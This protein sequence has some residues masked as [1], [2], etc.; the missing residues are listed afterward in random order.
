MSDADATLDANATV[1]AVPVSAKREVC[2]EFDTKATDAGLAIPYLVSINGKIQSKLGKLDGTR[3]IKRMVDIGSKVALYLNS[4]VHPD[5][6]STPVYAVEVGNNNVL[7]KI[8]EKTGHH[9]DLRPVIGQPLTS[10]SQGWDCYQAPLT[11]N[12]WMAISHRYSENEAQKCLAA[13]TP[14][15]VRQAISN[16]YRG[17]RSARLEIAFPDAHKLNIAFEEGGNAQDNIAGISTTTD[18]LTRTHPIAFESLLTEAYKLGITDMLVTSCWRPCYGSIAHRAGLGLDVCYI[19]TPTEKVKINRIGLLLKGHSSNPYVSDKEKTLR[20]EW[21]ELKARATREKDVK[22]IDAAEEKRSERVSEMKK[23]EPKIMRDLR[24]GLASH[25]AVSQ[26][27]DPWY[28]NFNT[29]GTGE[30]NINEQTSKVE[31]G[32]AHHLHI[33]IREHGII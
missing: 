6:R 10:G 16:I 18:V 22:A 24:A 7:I 17:L 12:I 1:K 8:T 3:K 2:Y 25:R 15:E 20:A 13:D 33:T 11:G 19:A 28:M 23:S 4:D 21:Q 9:A 30:A 14:I 31:K 27:L 5:H 29:H 26:L 32:H